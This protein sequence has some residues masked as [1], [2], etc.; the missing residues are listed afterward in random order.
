MNM[1]QHGGYEEH[2]VTY[3]VL[4]KLE[5]GYTGE[6]IHV[7]D[8]GKSARVFENPVKKEQKKRNHKIVN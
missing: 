6:H 1:S 4:R 5:T 3:L 8:S 2:R 7:S